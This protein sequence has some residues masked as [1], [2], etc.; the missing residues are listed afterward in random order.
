[1]RD[2]YAAGFTDQPGFRIT[3]TVGGQQASVLYF[4]G[5]VAGAPDTLRPLSDEID[6]VAVTERWIGA[7]CARVFRSTALT[8]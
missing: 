1:M 7:D 8:Q 3:V 2:V 4:V 5:E 6:R